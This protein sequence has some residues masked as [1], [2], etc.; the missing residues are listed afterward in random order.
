M[1]LRVACAGAGFFSQFHTGSWQRIPDVDLVGVCD[2]DLDKANA[3]GA[4][5]YTDLDTMMAEV[6]PDVLDVV[7]PPVAHADAIRT[8]ISRGGLQAII[9]QKPF[10]RDLEEA[11]A[12]VDLAREA[13]I[14]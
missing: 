11:E 6:Q 7:L 13:G 2:L 10:C 4:P 14:P 12:M 5:A 3:V 8:A 9:C 1:T